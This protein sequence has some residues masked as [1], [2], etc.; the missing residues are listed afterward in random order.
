VRLAGGPS[1]RG[2]VSVFSPSAQPWLCGRVTGVMTGLGSNDL[3]RLWGS[4]AEWQWLL[5]LIE[6]WPT[7]P[8]IPTHKKAPP[9]DW[10]GLMTLIQKRMSLNRF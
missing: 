5:E 9:F 3:A 4:A 1:W 8:I 10:R 6:I 7:I 2:L